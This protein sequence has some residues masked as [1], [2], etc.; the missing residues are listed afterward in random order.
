MTEKVDRVAPQDNFN[1]KFPEYQFKNP[2]LDSLFLLKSLFEEPPQKTKAMEMYE[3]WNKVP[4]L[5]GQ[6]LSLEFFNEI[7]AASK[8]L[9][10]NPEDFAALIYGESRFK[11]DIVSEDGK[12][13]GLIQM[14]DASLK[15]SIKYSLN[16]HGKNSR[17]DADMTMENYLKLSREKQ[18]IYAEAYIDML[19]DECG[20]KDKK[21]DGGQLWATIKSPKNVHNKKFRDK[22]TSMIESIKEVPAKYEPPFILKYI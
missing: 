14:T 10:C 21:I 2:K 18:L 1:I 8:R 20:L 19:K 22:L 16:K 4:D 17:V 15:S 11:P 13:K 6:G 7:E 12:Y 3:K 9:K 5:Q